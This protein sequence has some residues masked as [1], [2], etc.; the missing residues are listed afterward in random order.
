[1]EHDLSIGGPDDPASDFGAHLQKRL[2]ISR[3][4]LGECLTRYEPSRPYPINL[5]S[6]DAWY[7]TSA[8]A[9]E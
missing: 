7:P 5:G 4:E 9:A 3:Q 1:M 8:A 2:G 6:T